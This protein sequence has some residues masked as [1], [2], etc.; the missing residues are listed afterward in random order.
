M[1][2]LKIFKYINCYNKCVTFKFDLATRTCPW[3]YV[4]LRIARL[5]IRRNPNGLRWQPSVVQFYRHNQIE[6]YPF[7]SIDV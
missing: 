4:E 6:S 1:I 5:E 3:D 7:R 2:N